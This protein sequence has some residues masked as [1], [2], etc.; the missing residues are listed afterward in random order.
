MI[1]QNLQYSV[2][3][4]TYMDDDIGSGAGGEGNQATV[5]VIVPAVVV[6]VVITLI[7]VV[8]AV[9]FR[10]HHKRKAHPV[11]LRYICAA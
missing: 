5:G 8:M 3:I 6:P 7:I 9:I 1:G 11:G 10:Y 2:G 4:L